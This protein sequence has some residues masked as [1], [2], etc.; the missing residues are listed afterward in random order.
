VR[1]RIIFYKLNPRNLQADFR[2]KIAAKLFLR[3]IPHVLYVYVGSAIPKYRAVM[4]DGFDVGVI[5]VFRRGAILDDYKNHPKHRE[6]I[7]FIL[8]GWML[9]GSTA[10]DPAEEFFEHILSGREERP[11]VRNPAVPE[12]QVFWSGESIVELELE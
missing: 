12:D 5:I 4:I 1:A 3:E 2:V 6:W 10:A 9:E 11:I 8:C 7:R